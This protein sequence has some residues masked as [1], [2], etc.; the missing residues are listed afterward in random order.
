MFRGAGPSRR[1][2]GDHAVSLELSSRFVS[3]YFLRPARVSDVSAARVLI[4]DSVRG[5][6]GGLYSPAQIDASLTY[7]FGVDTQLI[8]DGTY[9]VIERDGAL[10]A[11][12]GWSGRKTLFGGDQHKSSD[13]NALDP[14]TDPA[15]IR[16]FFVHPAHARRGLARRIFDACHD[17]ARGAGFKSLEL[18]ST[19]PG[20]ALYKTLGFRE[21]EPIDVPMPGGLVLRCIRMDRTIDPLPTTTNSPTVSEE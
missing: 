1:G 7:V 19:L 12:G 20:V 14:A 17:A 8:D 4:D 9:F 21:L 13:D 10:A 2:G 5:L 16:A 15:R 18:A 3:E 6:S 11:V